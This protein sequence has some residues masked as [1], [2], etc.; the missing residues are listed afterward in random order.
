M[1][2]SDLARELAQRTDMPA[3]RVHLLLR[4]LADTVLEKLEEGEDVRLHGL[5][6]FSRAWR[7]RTA[8]RSLDS[9]RK[10]MIGGRHVARFRPAKRL[11]EG[12]SSH[13]DQSWRDDEHQAA[14][15]LARTL[16]SDLEAY[17]TTQRPSLE[18]TTP[19]EEVVSACADAFGDTWRQVWSTYAH[20]ATADP[21]AEYLIDAARRAW[22]SH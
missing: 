13:G 19:S 6:T 20:K 14:W 15:R 18:A 10:V 21:E 8:I 22:P 9:G 7:S 16:I 12:L 17:N 2:S 11:R 4:V 3:S 5:G 1:N